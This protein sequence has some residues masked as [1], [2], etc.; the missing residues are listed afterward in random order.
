[1]FAKDEATANRRVVVFKLVDRIDNLTP[2]LGIVL[3]AAEIQVSKNGAGFA[4]AL[5]ASAEIGG[6]FYSYEF[7][8]AD[9]D[10]VGNIRLKIDDAAA[11]IVVEEFEIRSVEHVY[12]TLYDGQINVASFGA[13]GQVP[14]VNG[15][16]GAPVVT[17]ADMRALADAIGYRRICYLDSVTQA[18]QAVSW[19]GYQFNAEG[20]G[21]GIISVTAG[22][23]YNRTKFSGMAVTGVF[24]AGGDDVGFSGV[25]LIN[26][27]LPFVMVA[28]NS[29]LAGTI[30]WTGGIGVFRD[31]FDAD[32]GV[33]APFIFDMN[34]LVTFA[35]PI[36][37]R[38]FAGKMRIDNMTAGGVLD[39]NVNGGV[40]TVDASCD[41]GSI[42]VYGTGR[43]INNSALVIDTSELID[44]E[45]LAI[46]R[47]HKDAYVFD[48]GPGAANVVL[49]AEGLVLT[50]RV[51]VF[52]TKTEAAAATKGAA[53]G[54]DGEI[55]ALDVTG[56]N[57]GVAGQLANMDIISQ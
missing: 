29:G 33:G 52:R 5:G 41:N 21:L 43:V 25:G 49:D 56:A 3:A 39:I 31:C 23:G 53:N 38:R 34:G 1:M 28:N 54:A 51:R 24:P 17:P 46:L 19:D 6:G 40:V 12:A 35:A 37:F 4:N 9:L 14:G 42:K 10:T 11:A 55:A 22:L 50:G 8:A 48:G 13:G 26:V 16:R 30:V 27:T 57:T 47:A 36:E 2:E 7:T 44:S 20:T 18:L 45:S 15:T 32:A